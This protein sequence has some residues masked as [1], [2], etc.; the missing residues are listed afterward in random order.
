M[1]KPCLGKERCVKKSLN[2]LKKFSERE[3][4][5]PML[6]RLISVRVVKHIQCLYSFYRYRT[7]ALTYSVS[8]GQAVFGPA[9]TEGVNQTP[10]SNY[11]K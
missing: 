5:H 8:I 7:I 4:G 3:A 9:E 2:H 1:S 11:L 10:L 6:Y